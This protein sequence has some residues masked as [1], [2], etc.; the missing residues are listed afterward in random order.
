MILKE[1]GKLGMKIV[2]GDANKIIIMPEDFR[3]FWKK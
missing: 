3:C 2:N 1:I